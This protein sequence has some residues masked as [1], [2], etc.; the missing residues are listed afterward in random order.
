MMDEF[1]ALFYPNHPLGNNILGS[2][3]TVKAFTRKDL[4]DFVATFFTAEN[5]VI[6]YVGNYSKSKLIE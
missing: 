5:L 4:L 3:K 6:S 1:D 2:K